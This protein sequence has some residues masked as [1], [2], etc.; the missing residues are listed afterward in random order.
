MTEQNDTI[1]W[2]LHLGCGSAIKPLPW[3]NVD[4]ADLPGV[5]LVWDLDSPFAWPWKDGTVGRI[6]AVSLFEHVADPVKFMTESHRILVPGGFLRMVVP[7]YLSRDAFTD[8][9]HRRFCT[10]HTF[11]YWVP[12]NIYHEKNNAAY[13]GVSF[14]LVRQMMDPGKGEIDILL[15]KIKATLAGRWRLSRRRSCRC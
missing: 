9:T 12:G 8:P 11:L 2:K 3:V 5:D 4:R 1:G 7:H 13:G 10:E 15:K 6:E 14:E